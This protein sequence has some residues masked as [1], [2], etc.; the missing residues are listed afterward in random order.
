MFLLLGA[1]ERGVVPL[2]CRVCRVERGEWGVFE[3]G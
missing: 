2:H 3:E 1:R